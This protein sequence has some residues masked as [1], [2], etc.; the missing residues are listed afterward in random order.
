MVFEGSSTTAPTR[1]ELVIAL[2][3]SGAGSGRWRQLGEMLGAHYQLVA[4]ERYGTDSVGPWTGDG[5]FTL[6]DEAART[7]AIIDG[8]DRMVHLVGHSYGGGLAL[9]V[10]LERLDRIASLALYEPSAFHL[11]NQIDGGAGPL[12]EILAITREAGNGV[13]TG[14]YRAAVAVQHAASTQT[15]RHYDDDEA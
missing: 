15:G 14:N 1:R 8:A 4:P 3:C 10:A 6:A 9:H 7:L 5:A 12:A 2:H 13:I 11:L